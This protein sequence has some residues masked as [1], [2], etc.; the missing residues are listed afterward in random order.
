MVQRF[1]KALYES[2][3]R[4]LMRR[5]QGYVQETVD[6]AVKKMMLTVVGSLTLLLGVVFV[7]YAG[8]VLLSESMS[9][10][11]ASLTIG[12]AV[13]IAGLVLLLV[14]SKSNRRQ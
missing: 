7:L 5:V 6:R 1:I 9:L 14:A 10:W 4:L 3:P 11:T 8:M 13:I 2:G 12:L